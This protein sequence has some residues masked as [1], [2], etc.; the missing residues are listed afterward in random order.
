MSISL[1]SVAS[2]E[3]AYLEVRIKIAVAYTLHVVVACLFSM[4]G[5]AET[6]S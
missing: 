5:R 1:S 2:V 3:D 4:L 6:T